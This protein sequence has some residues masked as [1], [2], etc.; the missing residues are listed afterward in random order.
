MRSVDN[1]HPFVIPLDLTR[2][3]EA[4]LSTA[5]KEQREPDKLDSKLSQQGIVLNIV[6]TIDPKLWKFCSRYVNAATNFYRVKAKAKAWVHDRTWLERNWTK[7]DSDIDLFAKETKTWGVTRET[8][9]NRHQ[10]LA[11]EVTSKFSDRPLRSEFAT[12]CD[13]VVGRVC[14]GW[15]SDSSIELCLSE[16]AASTE[17]CCVVSSLS[18]ADRLADGSPSSASR[19]QVCCASRQF[20]RESLRHYCR[21]S[22]GFKQPDSLRYNKEGLRGFIERWNESSHPGSIVKVDPVSWVNTPQQPDYSSCGVLE[23]A[24]THNVIAGNADLHCYNISKLDVDVMRLRMLWLL[25]LQPRERRMSKV[26]TDRAAK[27]DQRL[28]DKLE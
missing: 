28:Q 27:I 8:V 23:V 9:R 18:M 16:I 22:G 26:D 17:G 13:K 25:L 4:A 19:L 21:S 7:V 20:D 24:Y 5:R 14:R 15:L 2:S 11:N 1:M 6:A 12:K 10:A 3:M